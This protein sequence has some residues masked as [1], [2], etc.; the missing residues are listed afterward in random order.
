MVNLTLAL[1][2]ALIGVAVV[3]SLWVVLNQQ[4]PGAVRTL[5]MAV[6][7]RLLRGGRGWA[8]RLGRAIAPNVA[9]PGTCGG[10]NGCGP[11]SSGTDRSDASGRLRPQ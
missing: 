6:A 2:Y 3:L 5:R 9:D 8:T 7:L 10:C 1:Q 11:S 4:V